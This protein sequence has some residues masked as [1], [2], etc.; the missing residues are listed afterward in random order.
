MAISPDERKGIEEQ[1]ARLNKDIIH[2]KGGVKMHHDNDKPGGPQD[3][4]LGMLIRWRE[5]AEQF[6]MQH[7]AA[8][9][10]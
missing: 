3:Q 6:L 8:P 5:E 4:W 2:L 9:D 1:I 10:A 7:P